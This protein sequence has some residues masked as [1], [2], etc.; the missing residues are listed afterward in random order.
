[1]C[2]H[3]HE[4]MC[5]YYEAKQRIGRPQKI[6]RGDQDMTAKRVIP[7]SLGVEPAGK[8]GGS[9]QERFSAESDAKR[10]SDVTFVPFPS[11]PNIGPVNEN[12]TVST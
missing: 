10:S 11:L 9:P 1:M 2:R 12:E 7:W 4:Q 5:D 3:D 8:G 6:F